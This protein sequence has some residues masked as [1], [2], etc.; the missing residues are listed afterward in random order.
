MD[1]QK[2]NKSGRLGEWAQM[3]SQCRNS[4]KTVA[5]WCSEHGISTK[6]YYYRLRRLCEAIPE[7]TKPNSLPLP[8]GEKEPQFAEVMPAERTKRGSAAINIRMGCA[9]V[10]IL[11]G[12]EAVTIEAVLRALS[13]IC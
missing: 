12:A 8:A 10:E 7:P 11:N 5:V 4:G 2:L 3:A 9:E 6:T 13:Q 1:I